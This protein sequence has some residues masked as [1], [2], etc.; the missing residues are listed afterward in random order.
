MLS[1]IIIII[2]L[3]ILIITRSMENFTTDEAIQN[4]ASLYNTQNMKV[5]N[6]DVTGNTKTASMEVAGNIKAAS[7]DVA[8]NMNASGGKFN[9]LITN[10]LGGS[11]NVFIGMRKQTNG[12]DGQPGQMVGNHADLHAAARPCFQMCPPGSYMVG[13][14]N[15]REF[16]HKHPLCKYFNK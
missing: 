14:Q 12:C 7:A 8:G 10:Q 15:G 9:S 13:I 6:L 2:L 11:D 5:T 4:V 16:D 3:T 1:V